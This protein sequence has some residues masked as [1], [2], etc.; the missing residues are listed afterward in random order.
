MTRRNHKLPPEVVDPRALYHQAKADPR[1]I[2]RI[3]EREEAARAAVQRAEE[4]E[5]HWNSCRSRKARGPGIAVGK[6]ARRKAD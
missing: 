5:A 3:K 6:A 4:M 1:R 2:A